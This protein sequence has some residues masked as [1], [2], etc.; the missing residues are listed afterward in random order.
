LPKLSAD[1]WRY[2]ICC[3]SESIDFALRDSGRSHAMPRTIGPDFLEDLKSGLLFPIL[4]RVKKDNTLMLAFREGYVNVY[5]RG[6]S[7]LRLSK[8]SVGYEAWFDPKYNTSFGLSLPNFP[9]T[10]CTPSDVSDLIAVLPS[11]KTA[12][13]GHVTTNDKVER[14]IQ[15]ML[16]RENNYSSTSNASEYFITDIEMADR[17]LGAR[18]DFVGFRW[19]ATDR[20]SGNRCRAVLG[21]IKHGDSGL[22]G[23]TSDLMKHIRDTA[24][25]LKTAGSQEELRSTI[26]N[27]FRNLIALGLIRCNLP[28]SLA[29]TGPSITDENPELL[30]VIANANPRSK[31]MSKFLSEL[32]TWEDEGAETEAPFDLLFFVPVCTGYAL[33]SECM[34]NPAEFR[35][36]VEGRTQA[37]RSL[38]KT[39]P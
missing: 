18:L 7:L 20:R 30:V 24:E 29:E 5:Y 38:A 8:E 31:K 27:H 9:Q 36:Y 11:M 34:L 1:E 19:R 35:A 39:A 6:G 4:D 21:E 17:R 25:L 13:D 37:G 12:I 10:L 23:S 15:Q 3:S 14:E 22:T 2:R 33:H 26:E 32:A 28:E 16:V